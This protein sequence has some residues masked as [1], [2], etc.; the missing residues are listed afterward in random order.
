M[1]ELNN[2]LSDVGNGSTGPRSDWRAKRDAAYDR[3]IAV[4][5]RRRAREFEALGRPDIA[6]RYDEAAQRQ[7]F[8]AECL[9]E[10]RKFFTEAELAELRAEC[11]MEVGRG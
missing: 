2:G 5:Y 4:T 7:E 10:T 8:S 6:K 11:G 1:S 9:D 3:D